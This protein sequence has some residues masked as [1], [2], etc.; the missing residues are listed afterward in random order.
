MSAELLNELETSRLRVWNE[1]QNW[2]LDLKGREMNAEEAVQWQR[3]NTRIDQLADEAQRVRDQNKNDHEAG[4]VRQAQAQAFGREPDDKGEAQN[5][6]ANLRSWVRG[7]SR[8]NA[9]DDEGKPFNGFRSNI[10]RVMHERE[11][12]RMGA[13]PEEIRALA[14]D[15]GSVASAVPTLLDRSLYAVLEANI[16]ALRMPTQRIT[17]ES[18]A[19]M[20]FAKVTAN[21]IA[22]QVSGQGTT[23]AGTDPTFGKTTLTPVKYAELIKV[24]SEVITDEGVNVISF[25][26]GNIGRA[27]GRKVNEAIIANMVGGV[28]VGSGGTVSTG[29]TL[30]TPTYD[31][32]VNLLYSVND[33]YRNDNSAWLARDSTAGT[34]R[35]L[36]DGAGGTEGAV[37]WQP[38]TQVGISGQRQPDQLLGY[39]FFTD[40]G[41]ASMASNNKILFYGDWN[42]FI[43]R[44]VGDVMVERNDSVGFATD[45]VFFRGKWRA[46]GEYQD[47][48]AVNLLKQS[49]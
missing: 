41:V 2:L 37:L 48:T 18:G 7:D 16:A 45:E 44:T 31:H 27:V 36:R 13:S 17:T 26:A 32:L 30:V 42:G 35:K 19:P 34:L 20:D 29:G 47:L 10:T 46:D 24:A 39:P 49:I 28:V 12:A 3:Y 9:V 38:S 22:T 4:L 15:T 33:A 43:L 21:A 5:L 1:A 6:V 14:W 25:L 11:L 23:L 40:P 8:M